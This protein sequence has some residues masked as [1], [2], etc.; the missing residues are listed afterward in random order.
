MIRGSIRS[1]DK[2]GEM[3]TPDGYSRAATS[4]CTMLE[5][6][7]FDGAIGR[8]EGSTIFRGLMASGIFG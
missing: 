2:L 8:I 7:W 3:W 6:G 4:I 1:R 5:K